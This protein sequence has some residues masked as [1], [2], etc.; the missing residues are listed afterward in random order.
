MILKNIEKSRQI[1][2]ADLV[3]YNEGQIISRTL[4]QNQSLSITLFAFDAGEE[5][6][7]IPRA[8]TLWLRYWTAAR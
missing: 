1:N 8:E 4:V 5:I 6:S 7:S 3:S 2:L